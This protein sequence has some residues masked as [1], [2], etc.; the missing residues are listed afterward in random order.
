MLGG[1]GFG[2][3][4]HFVTLA[5]AAGVRLR[6]NIRAKPISDKRLFIIVLWAF[7]R[8]G[9]KGRLCRIVHGLRIFLVSAGLGG[10]GGRTAGAFANWAKLCMKS[11]FLVAPIVFAFC[12]TAFFRFFCAALR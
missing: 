10:D 3:V 7:W 9:G 4:L 8:F 1:C 12:C 5:C 2:I 6:G 11:V